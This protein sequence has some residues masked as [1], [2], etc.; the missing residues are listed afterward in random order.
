MS[1]KQNDIIDEA[2]EEAKAEA[3][4][5]NQAFIEWLVRERQ[6]NG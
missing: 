5:A 4:A 2:R 3:R 1:N 6:S